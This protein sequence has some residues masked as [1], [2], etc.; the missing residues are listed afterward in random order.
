VERPVGAE[1]PRRFLTEPP[2]GFRSATERVS[3]NQEPVRRSD[4]TGQLEFL[5]GRPTPN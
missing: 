2:R 3:P 1:P 4:S 5:T